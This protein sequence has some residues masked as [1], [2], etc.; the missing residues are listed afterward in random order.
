S[1]VTKV[2]YLEHPDR[3]APALGTGNEPAEMP[4]PPGRDLIAE[5]RELGRPMLVVRLGQR[6]LARE[7]LAH[8]SVP[9]TILHP[10]ERVLPP[11]ARPP[12]VPPAS[13]CF[14]DPVLGPA[15]PD[16]ECL[17][18]GGDRGLPAGIGADGHVYG[19]DAEDTVAEYTDSRGQRRITCSNRVCI[20]VP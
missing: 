16:A 6:T 1:L 9:G 15:P 17:R 7:E 20:C 5:A 8:E 19:L 11:A 3:A 10:G 4:I 14:F 2:V 12:C 13:P 18:D